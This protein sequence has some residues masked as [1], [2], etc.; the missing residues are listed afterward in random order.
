MKLKATI[1]LISLVMSIL[2][3]LSFGGYS[4]DNQTPVIIT[5][6]VCRTT[7]PSLS[8]NAELPVIYE[9]TCR[10]VHSEF[11]GFY[12]GSNPTFNP[13]LIAFQKDHPPRA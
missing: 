9:S 1:I 13:F 3:P 5:L 2:S 4:L 8:V 11:A 10:L 12:D 7:T 6:D